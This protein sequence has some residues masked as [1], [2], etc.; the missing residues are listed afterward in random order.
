MTS[1]AAVKD[2]PRYTGPLA[3]FTMIKVDEEEDGRMEQFQTP[4]D[5]DSPAEGKKPMMAS[6]GLPNGSKQ[7]QNLPKRW[8]SEYTKR[9][10]DLRLETP[11]ST[12]TEDTSVPNSPSFY[13]QNPPVSLPSEQDPQSLLFKHHLSTLTKSGRHTLV[14]NWMFGARSFWEDQPPRKQPPYPQST[15]SP[16]VMTKDERANQPA[17]PYKKRE[18]FYEDPEIVMV[19]QPPP[20]TSSLPVA[21]H[22]SHLVQQPH[23]EVLPTP[24]TEK[25][26]YNIA[27]Y[28]VVKKVN[29]F[30]Q[31]V[32][33]YATD[34]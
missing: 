1:T 3:Q 27:P 22:N 28:A 23:Q 18:P 5:S 17:Q 7:R 6:L 13:S 2:H 9:P 30:S 19:S 29:A 4:T 15:L 16:L 26:R 32:Y 10:S 21:S 24:A 34:V 8:H 11:L 12:A 14:K 25:P 33:T 31:P 20:V